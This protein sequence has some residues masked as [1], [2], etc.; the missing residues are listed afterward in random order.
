[1]TKL[2]DIKDRIL[3]LFRRKVKPKIERSI[4]VGYWNGICPLCK[5]H[6]GIDLY[7]DKLTGKKHA[8]CASC[9]KEIYELIEAE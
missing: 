5:E 8:S 2:S 6:I 1:M 4:I 7:K 3:H 9:N